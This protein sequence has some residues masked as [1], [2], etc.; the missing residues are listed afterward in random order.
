[1]SDPERA[2][3]A[4]ESLTPGGS[5]YFNDPDRCVAFVKQARDV[6]FEAMKNAIRRRKALEARCE[7]LGAKCK[8]LEMAL[9]KCVADLPTGCPGGPSCT[10]CLQRGEACEVGAACEEARTLLG[11]TDTK[12]SQETEAKDV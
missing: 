3:R 1:M 11:E 2:M 7:Q 9:Q 12:P 5:E 4:L 6:L 8:Q 10:E